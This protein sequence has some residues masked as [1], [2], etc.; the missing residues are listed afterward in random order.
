MAYLATV[1]DYVTRARELVQDTVEPYRYPDTLFMHSLTEGYAEVFRIRPDLVKPPLPSF[2]TLPAQVNIDVRYRLA[3]VY[4][5]AGNV[6][7]IDEEP[8]QDARASAFLKA[9]TT[10]LLATAS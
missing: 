7:I 2:E 3:L 6:H 9:F 8:A 1:Q 4:F 10:K 5:M